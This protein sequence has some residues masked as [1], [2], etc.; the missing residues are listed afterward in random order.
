MISFLHNLFG[1]LIFHIVS[2]RI[3]L[4]RIREDTDL[5]QT[6]LDKEVAQSLILRICFAGE[7][8][9]KSRTDGYAGDA[10]PQLLNQ[11]NHLLLSVRTMHGFEH[12]IM[13][14]L[15]GQI[16]ILAD[17]GFRRIHINELIRKEFRIAIE[18]AHPFEL[19]HLNHFTQQFSECRTV[20]DVP[21]IV[22][23]VLRDKDYF[24][25]T[26]FRELFHFCTDIFNLAA[27]E[28]AANL[29]DGAEGATIVTAFG[30]LHISGII[31]RGAD[32][33]SL[34]IIERVIFSSQYHTMAFQRFL[35][36]FH[37]APPGTGAQNGI[38]FWQFVQQ[39]LLVAL[40]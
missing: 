32:A 34:G 1:N 7:A 3:L 30:N 31:R 22:G 4:T 33:G 37:N 23:A 13:G 39:F 5:V 17:L 8:H 18:R 2:R 9:D 40:A 29:R 25:H 10:F 38:G 36:R 16:H 27:A 11:G 12:G 24:P 35:H 26:I 21:A 28:L 14:M 20:V 15:Q 6:L 19:R